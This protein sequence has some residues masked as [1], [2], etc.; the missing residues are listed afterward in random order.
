MIVQD[1]GFVISRGAH[2]KRTPAGLSAFLHAEQKQKQA[3][4][5]LY[6]TLHAVADPGK[7]IYLATEFTQAVKTI[8]HV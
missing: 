1:G 4:K 8:P 7:A 3:L 6:A 5:R 2:F